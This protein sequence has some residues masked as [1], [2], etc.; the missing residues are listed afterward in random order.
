MSS[1]SSNNKPDG[2]H[3]H[4]NEPSCC[5]HDKGDSRSH[6]HNH[7]HDHDHEHIQDHQH[8]HP[9][10]HKE[11]PKE[12]KF[13]KSFKLVDI[14]T[15][16]KCEDDCCNDTEHPQH[17]KIEDIS[18]L[19]SD[20]LIGG[21]DCPSCALTIEKSVKGIKGISGVQVNYNTGKM[22]VGYDDEI[23]LDQVSNTVTKLGYTVEVAQKKDRGRV[24]AIEGMDCS[25]CALTIEK[26]IKALPSVK[27]VHVNFSTGKMMAE[28]DNSAEDIIKEVSKAGYKAM[29][30][31]KTKQSTIS[32]KD[33][34]GRNLIIFSGALLLFGWIGSY[35]SASPNFTTLLYAVSIIIGGYKPA[36]SAYYA[37]KS[38][39]LDMNV[40]MTAAVLGSAAIG[41]W[42]EGAT[43]VW[44]FAL[45]N[46]LQT[47]SIEKTRN[48]IRGLIDLAP[49]EAFVKDGQE[50]VS[51]P[52]EDILVDDI[53]VVKPGDKIPLDGLV[54]AGESSVNQAPITGES[55]PVD[56][57]LGDSV[58]A[59]TINEH[60]SLEIKVT[61]LVEDTTISK[62]IHLVEEAQEQ[63]APTE[64]FVDK[65]AR[66]Y[67]PIVFILAL[68]V[69]VL[70]PLLGNGT[71]GSWFYK[72]LELL[73][74]A[75][76]CALVIS[77]PVAIVS[78]IGNAA[79]NGVLIKGGAFLEIAGRIS[80]I[81]FDKTG[82]L[83]EGKPKVAQVVLTGTSEVE[84]LS[85]AR[86]L[87]EYSTHPIAK[88]V[89][90][91]AK[92]K[93][94]PV[95]HGDTFR[96]IVGK[97]VSAIIGDS[98][99]FAGNIKLFKELSISLGEL[100]SQIVSLQ[101]EG[102]TIVI[103][104]TNENVLGVLAVSDAIRSTSVKALKGLQAVGIHQV[105][106]LTGDNEGTAKKVASE[107]GVTRYF[108]ELMPEDK[109]NAV[110][111]LQKE[112]HFVAMVGDGIN[113]APALATADLGIAMGG[114]GTDTAMETADIVLM[115]DNL[116]KLPHTLHLS[117]K[118]VQIIK[119]NIWFSIVIKAIALLLIFPGI[120]TLWIAVLSDTG[121]A[122]LV[123]INSMRLLRLRK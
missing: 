25:S 49:P 75:C 32:K 22:Q 91:Y 4:G 63:K 93:G 108:A 8:V 64:A 118:A 42:L 41:Q 62:I 78:A 84:L 47:M 114:A 104:G 106:M 13:K 52:V 71:W 12:L 28:H 6:E 95:R 11:Q 103:I 92:D 57:H 79:K 102:N 43:I 37:V 90:E 111:K 24:Y 7:N 115:A 68:V 38:R 119:Q 69:M 76:P 34:S 31:S 2:E 46:V 107:T 100:E 116:E 86:T 48:S 14:S 58:Y 56:K 15:P 83:T 70:P 97:G 33:N 44:L 77:T 98:E 105:V 50:L 29:L 27:S 26:H 54:I 36:R 85:I 55:I 80:T 40:L 1:N 51:K 123:I 109:V 122:L 113:D 9:H 88:A 10:E 110:K 73:V 60:G 45:G 87:E 96:N 39:S 5:N 82:T 65:F 16:E 67:T 94:V 20:Y 21:M 120:L 23:A 59:G 72:G 99:Y 3:Q 117:R 35:T 61:K 81:A 30:V 19:K 112:G 18:V 17:Q 121:A 101:Q 66:V 53:I 74:I 89:V